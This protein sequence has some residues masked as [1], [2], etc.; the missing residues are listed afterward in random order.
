MPQIYSVAYRALIY[1]GEPTNDELKGF[2]YIKE[3]VGP[4]QDI[5]TR[6]YQVQVGSWEAVRQTI[7]S[8]L[9]RR[10]FS[11]VWIL[12]EVALAKEALVLCGEYG[13]TWE[14]FRDL[15]RDSQ[16]TDP[17]GQVLNASPLFE[18]RPLPKVLE[19]SARKYRDSSQ[20][21]PLL[22]LARDSQAT[23]QRDKVFA[24][25]GMINLADRLGYVPDYTENVEETY[26]RAVVL[27]CETN[28]LTSILERAVCHRNIQTLPPWVTDW[29]HPYL[30]KDQH[31]LM[32]SPGTT[33]QPLS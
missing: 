30:M 19:F 8:L 28:G 31:R 14:Y 13:V 1:L 15:A 23:D 6:L 4:N 26:R 20:L 25:F 17:Q 12:Q 27:V 21:L 24:V 18:S 33:F 2:Q 22:D 10:Y 9:N 16:A 11:R 7:G 3:R 29:S 5:V 32:K